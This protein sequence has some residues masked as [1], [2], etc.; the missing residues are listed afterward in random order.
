MICD[1]DSRSRVLRQVTSN[2]VISFS[3]LRLMSGELSLITELSR[4]VDHAMDQDAR[5]GHGDFEETMGQDVSGLPRCRNDIEWDCVCE[6]LGYQ[7][8]RDPVGRY[9]PMTRVGSE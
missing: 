8:P 5:I 4:C 1:H 7:A 6:V 2:S 3:M 9:V